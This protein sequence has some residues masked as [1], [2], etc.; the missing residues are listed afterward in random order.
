[1]NIV[2]LL[3]LVI[4]ISLYSCTHK[5]NSTV[6]GGKISIKGYKS[7]IGHIDSSKQVNVPITKTPSKTTPFLLSSICDTIK[8]IK[9]E[10][11][12]ECLLADIDKIKYHNKKLYILDRRVSKSLFIFDLE[13]KFINKIKRI[14]RGPGEYTLLQN[15]FID[16]KNNQL[17]LFSDNHKLL[18]F[19]CTG[20]YL[21]ERKLNFF[22]WSSLIVE[23]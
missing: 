5:T 23:R 14:G 18:Y 1:M 7:S 8:Y 3:W 9:L 13:G 16:K 19:D 10:T 17:V 4:I 6:S 11:S 20:K 22:F 2:K 12:K 21:S 15:F